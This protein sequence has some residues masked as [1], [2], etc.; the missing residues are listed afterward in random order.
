MQRLEDYFQS[1]GQLSINTF[2]ETQVNKD[3]FL[4]EAFI[5]IDLIF[6]SGKSV[7]I[8]T[9]AIKGILENNEEVLYLPMLQAEPEVEKTYNFNT[10]SSSSRSFALTIDGR[11][12]DALEQVLAGNM[13]NGVAEVSLLVNGGTIADRYILMRGQ[14]IGGITFGAK[15]ELVELEI[16]DPK[17]TNEAIVPAYLVDNDAFSTLPPDYIGKRFPQIY[18]SHPFVPCIRLTESDVGPNFLIAYGHNWTVS[19]V[20]VDGVEYASSD[21]DFGYEIFEARSDNGIPY[22]GIDFVYPAQTL[23]NPSNILWQNQSVFASISK[24]ETNPSIFNAIRTIISSSNNYGIE[25]V[26]EKLITLSESKAP[27]LKANCLINADSSDSM[28]TATKYIEQT[29]LESFPMLSASFTGYGYGVVLTDRRHPIIT[30]HL[31]RGKGLIIDRLSAIK[32]YEREELYNEFTVRYSYNTSTDNYEKV[33]SSNSSNNTLCAY[34]ESK[35]GRRSYP[36]IDSVVVY[37]DATAGYILGWLTAH[38]TLPSYYVEYEAVASLYFKVSL[39]DM[40]TLTD[41]KLGI[42]DAKCSVEK[43]CYYRGKCII[44]LRAWL[45]YE[46]VVN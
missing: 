7:R 28:A 23:A 30:A 16:A 24:D 40:V 22:T 44:G 33:I 3:P 4:Y 20:F 10:G 37:D 35:I 17:V 32:E 34:S 8:A 29:L 42:V 36:P 41:D 25:G 15:E 5:V 21:P 2:W 45:L 39:G 14:M 1:N 19:K 11:H 46:T 18:F 27:F 6:A 13:L 38:L 12:V 9:D 43:I 31:D 26:D